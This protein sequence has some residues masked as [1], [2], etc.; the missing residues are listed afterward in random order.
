DRPGLPAAAVFLDQL[1]QLGPLEGA[2]NRHGDVRRHIAAAK[3]GVHLIARQGADTLNRAEDAIA[4]AMV[5]E[6][7]P[8]RVIERQPARLV[9]VLADLLDD[10]L[11]LHVKVLDTETWPQDIAEHVDGLR[12]ILRQDG[13][14][15]DGVLLTGKGIGG[16]ADA[17]EVAV[18]RE[19]IASLA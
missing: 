8:A 5:A 11:L 9:L 2:G 10:Y 7:Q 3:V 16:G 18:D 14:V 6:E 17:V 1:D 4:H 13:G 19:G 12:Q 15:K